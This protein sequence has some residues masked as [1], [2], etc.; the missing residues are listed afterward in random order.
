MK[1]GDRVVLTRYGSI[2]WFTGAHMR[3]DPMPI[4]GTIVEIDGKH[5]EGNHCRE[6]KIKFDDD[7]ELWY[8]YEEIRKI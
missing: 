4:T 1:I 8:G 2:R 7:R 3:D 5:Y 6:C